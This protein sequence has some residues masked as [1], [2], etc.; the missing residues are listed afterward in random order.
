[1]MSEAAAT[2]AAAEV[3]GAIR[4][5]GEAV[6]VAVHTLHQLGCQ[7][8]PYAEGVDSQP[9]SQREEAQET[10][11]SP[12]GPDLHAH[13]RWPARDGPPDR[14]QQPALTTAAASITSSRTIGG[15]V[16][17]HDRAGSALWPAQSGPQT[18][19]SR[20][21]GAARRSEPSREPDR[22]TVAGGAGSPGSG[23]GSRSRG[24]DGGSVG[25]VA[26]HY[27]AAAR[28]AE[29]ATE[30]D[31][32]AAAVAA[33]AVE[34]AEAEA[35][36]EAERA[37]DSEVGSMR[38]VLPVEPFED[39]TLMATN[40]SLIEGKHAAM[41][42]IAA[43]VHGLNELFME[44]GILVKVQGEEVETVA[45]LAQSVADDVLSARE[46]LEKADREQQQSGCTLS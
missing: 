45:S 17:G 1:M 23:D 5:Y 43:E 46:E 21:A 14:Q 8:L 29:T 41:R 20:A 28:T 12:V 2:A 33:A 38:M 30:M 18:A 13:V 31:G 34:Q 22:R 44:L 37:A 7:P 15:G 35:E 24:D 26:R 16:A 6:E 10:G 32:Q 11:L 3:E 9:N 42:A 25:G 39:S 4:S 40:A 36:A 19:D 27:C